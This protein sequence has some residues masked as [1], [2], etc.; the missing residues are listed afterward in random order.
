MEMRGRSL[1]LGC[2]LLL[3]AALASTAR[4]D[5][6]H[7][8]GGRLEP[9]PSLAGRPFSGVATDGAG[10]V[11]AGVRR[12]SGGNSVVVF[13]PDGR[14]IRDFD[15]GGTSAGPG[16][17][18]GVGCTCDELDLAIGPD[19]LLYVGQPVPSLGTAQDRYVSVYTTS[20]TP[21]RELTL[22]DGALLI[23]DLEVDA[24]GSIFVLA[25]HGGF[26]ATRGAPDEIMRVS[27]SGAVTARF[28]LT[29]EESA[30]LEGDLGGL[31]LGPDGSMW[32]TTHRE[33]SRLI[34]L[35]PDGS[36]QPAPPL[37]TVAPVKNRTVKDV[38]FA[39]DRLYIAAREPNGLIVITQDGELVDRL[40]GEARQVAV[41]DKNVYVTKLDTGAA[42]AS[43][44]TAQ[45]R[46][47]AIAWTVAFE[48]K[49]PE[50]PSGVETKGAC[51]S[52][53]A[54]HIGTL[55]HMNVPSK[56]AASCDFFYENYSTPSC[57]NGPAVR[58]INVY[59]GG[60]ALS[61][62]VL[63]NPTPPTT[64]RFEINGR[65]IGDGG[66]IVV[67]WSCRD[68][69][70]PVFEVKGS[71]VLI[72]PSGTVLDRKTGKPIQFATVRLQFKP[73]AGGVFGIP[74]LSLMRP[75]VHP[76][77]TGPDGAFGWDVAPGFWR[78][79][80][81]AFGYRQFTSET[82]E[83]PPEVTGLRLR[84]KRSSAFRRLIDP[85]GSVG[86]LKIGGRVGRKVGGLRIGLQPSGRIREIGVTS[87]SFRT[88]AGI[89]LRST[90]TDLLKA[91][92]TAKQSGKV[93]K[94]TKVLRFRRA[95]FSVRAGRVTGIRIAR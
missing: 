29:A 37:E 45:S 8:Q 51:T 90:E 2:T 50:K 62:F 91:Y 43:V 89:K 71:I 46:D 85:A 53:T 76:Q 87:K 5:V 69:L 92:P 94:G 55:V 59:L 49:P 16:E 22:S 9:P 21:V 25:R 81:N 64:A 4:A 15:I 7:L 83:I 61:S 24:A 34:H 27:P 78:L 38:E 39:N 73:V 65:D 86:D 48:A 84:M 77:T 63:R 74:S 66:A 82:F 10:N 58:P 3:T 18:R 68:T 11:Y 32:V 93:R 31:A 57:S 26:G 35:A 47:D 28:A 52:V 1:A 72:D 20:G 60:R 79:V 44:T 40:P 70:V 12:S 19:N 30:P 80:L 95:F 75:Q 13:G 14:Y 33:G 23:G 54:N 42:P 41:A 56:S 88:A 6:V 67:E 17:G 36:R